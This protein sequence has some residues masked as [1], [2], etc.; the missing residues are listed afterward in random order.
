MFGFQISDLRGNLTYGK[1]ALLKQPF[2]HLQ[3]VSFH[4]RIYRIPIYA[5]KAFFHNR[6]GEIEPFG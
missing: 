2:R 3:A 5:P 1:S 6:R 4:I